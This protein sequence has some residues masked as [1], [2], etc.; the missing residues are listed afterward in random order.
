[1]KSGEYF[2]SAGINLQQ[3]Q[4]NRRHLPAGRRCKGDGAHWFNSQFSYP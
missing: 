1:L 4:L 2:P 3:L